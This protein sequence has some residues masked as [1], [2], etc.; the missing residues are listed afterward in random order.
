MIMDD[1]VFIL[2]AGASAAYGY[3]TGFE[4]AE[5]IKNFLRNFLYDPKFASKEKADLN[6]F[7]NQLV[8]PL[9]RLEQ[10]YDSLLKAS[11]YSI[12]KF[13]ENRPDYLDLGKLLIAYMLK[14]KENDYALF[15]KLKH[16]NWFAELFNRIDANVMNISKNRISFIT[17]NYD[18]SLEF[19]LYNLLKSRSTKGDNDILQAF[20]SIPII[21]VYGSLGC[22]P[23]ENSCGIPYSYEFTPDQIKKMAANIEI[24]SNETETEELKAAHKL[25]NQ[26]KKIYFIGCGYDFK[27]LNRLK[28]IEY[29]EGKTIRGTAKGIPLTLRNEITTFFNVEIQ[30]NSGDGGKISI[31]RPQVNISLADS[32]DTIMDFLDKHVVF[33]A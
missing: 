33:S 1:S 24:M 26:A 15:I 12:D 25:L 10:F 4:L 29:A 13:L 9:S 21:H 7:F 27:N 5:E 18:R 19:F 32:N 16:D 2:G 8:T 14:K 28:I 3:P 20:R 17:F 6:G 30:V 31:M 11:T 22:F 23:W